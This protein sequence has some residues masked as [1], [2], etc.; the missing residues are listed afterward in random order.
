METQQSFHIK[1]VTIIGAGILGA[2]IAIQAT[3]F[4]FK[5][6]VY[7]SAEGAFERSV[8]QFQAI[9]EARKKGPVVPIE[10]WND[11]ISKVQTDSVMADALKDADLV[12]EAVPEDLFP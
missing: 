3:C 6:K 9:M 8:Q 4:D 1:N 5:V 7:D 10:K 12:I 11:G 2:Q